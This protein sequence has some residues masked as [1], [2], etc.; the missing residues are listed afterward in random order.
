MSGYVDMGN[1]MDETDVA[2]EVLVFMVV[3]IQSHWKAPVA[4]Y[5]TKSVSPETQKVLVVHALEE[6]HAR[7]TEDEGVPG[8]T[9]TESLCS[10]STAHT[11]GPW[12]FTV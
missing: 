7:G 2:T 9:N 8:C 10:G 11:E 3:G 6:L 4:Y 5:L 1:G 12:L